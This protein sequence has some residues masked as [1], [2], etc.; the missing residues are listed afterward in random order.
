MSDLIITYGIAAGAFV[1]FTGI[2]FGVRSK[3]I[4]KL[5]QESRQQKQVT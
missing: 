4:N 2:L 5:I 3:R 1:V